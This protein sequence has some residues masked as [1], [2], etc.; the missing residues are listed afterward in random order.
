M[1]RCDPDKRRICLTRNGNI[2][3]VIK[4]EICAH[5]SYF[6]VAPKDNSDCLSSSGNS[7]MEASC[8]MKLPLG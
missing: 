8:E 6:D 7:K 3:G 4:S 5:L 2:S 1:E